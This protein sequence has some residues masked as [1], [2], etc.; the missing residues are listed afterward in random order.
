MRLLQLLFFLW[1]LAAP[2]FQQRSAFTYSHGAII[3][4][5]TTQRKLALVFTADEFA[6]G[7]AIIAQTLQKHK[8]K[9]SFFLTGRFYRNAG[10]SSLIQQLRRSGHYLGPHSD[11]HLLYCDWNKRDSLL[12]TQQ[13][14]NNDLRECYRAM[15][16]QGIRKQQASW[17][18]PPY[19]WYNDTIAAWTRALQLQLVN[20]TPG[21]LSHADYTFPEMGR[22]YRSCSTIL[23]SVRDYEQRQPAGLNGFLLLMHAGADPRRTDHCWQELDGLLIWLE[24][25]NYKFVTVGDLLAGE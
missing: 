18:L 16:A 20:Y 15:Q 22:S 17:F 24:S 1:P 8:A 9:A 10:N 12:V 11:Q 5:D 3:R 21:T 23:Q 4:G 2:V 14:F 25:K 19:E 13:Q 6:N 7:G